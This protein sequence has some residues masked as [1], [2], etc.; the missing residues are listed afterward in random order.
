M[1][2]KYMLVLLMFVF[3]LGSVGKADFPT[4]T[5]RYLPKFFVD[6]DLRD[7]FFQCLSICMRL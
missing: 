7:H 6:Q 1:R 2:L 5:D 4:T 3:V